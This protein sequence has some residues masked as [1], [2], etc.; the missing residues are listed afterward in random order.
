MHLPATN[1]MLRCVDPLSPTAKVT[2][3]IEN[4]V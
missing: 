3:P 1:P 4:S 2:L